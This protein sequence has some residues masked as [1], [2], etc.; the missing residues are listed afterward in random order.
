MRFDVWREKRAAAETVANGLRFYRYETAR[1]ERTLFC[2]MQFQPKA[3]KPTWHSG[4]RTLED[5][6]TYIQKAIEA[7]DRHQAA[8]KQYRK[9]RATGD[10]SLAD[11]GAVF[12]Y[13]WGYD[14]TNVD[15]FQ[16]VK[17]AGLMVWIRPI[18][19]ESIKGSEGFMSDSVRPAVGHFADP[20]RH[21]GL[22][23]SAPQHSGHDIPSREIKPHE[24]EPADPIKKRLG[25]WNGKPS[26]SFDHGVG[27]LVEV[28]RFG[29]AEPLAVGRHYRSWYA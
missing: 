10:P 26:L 7:Y 5:R 15:Y 8:K 3:T 19:C 14:Q 18:A 21:C 6:E 1:G 9:E 25:F 29:N 27:S 28:H 12:C 20:C 4:F 16:V 13:S 24:Y 22:Y 2:A 23:R 11:P 17:R